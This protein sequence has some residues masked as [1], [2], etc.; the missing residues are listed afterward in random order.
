MLLNCGTT[1]WYWKGGPTEHEGQKPQRILQAKVTAFSVM[2]QT[3]VLPITLYGMDYS[4]V[5]TGKAEGST[6]SYRIGYMS[7]DRKT[8]QQLSDTISD[9]VDGRLTGWRGPGQLPAAGPLPI[10]GRRAHG[11]GVSPARVCHSNA[12]TRIRAIGIMSKQS[13]YMHIYAYHIAKHAINKKHHNKKH[14]TVY[15]SAINRFKEV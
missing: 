7:H 8:V 11:R 10:L 1:A 3:A 4:T 12:S 2:L 9:M 13:L 5:H 15:I 6:R 14:H